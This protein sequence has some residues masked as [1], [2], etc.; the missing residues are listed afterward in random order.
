MESMEWFDDRALDDDTYYYN[1]LWSLII[2]NGNFVFI[3]LSEGE[4]NQVNYCIYNRI[5]FNTFS[6]INN[7]VVCCLLCTII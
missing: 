6:W 5:I 7:S 3:E 2:S 1:V 4:E